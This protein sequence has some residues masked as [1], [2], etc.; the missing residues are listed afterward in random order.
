MDFAGATFMVLVVHQDVAAFRAAFGLGSQ[1][2][3]LPLPRR[4][5]VALVAQ[6]STAM[7]TVKF[8]VPSRSDC[9]ALDEGEAS[10]RRRHRIELFAASLFNT[11]T[12]RKYPA[13][14]GAGWCPGDELALCLFTDAVLDGK[15]SPHVRP[16][17]DV[18]E[19]AERPGV[20]ELYGSSM[21]LEL[22]QPVQEN[23][24]EVL[25]LLYA[26]FCSYSQHF[27]WIWGQ[28][29]SAI[30]AATGWRLSQRWEDTQGFATCADGCNAKRASTSTA[31]PT[32][33]NVV[34][35]PKRLVSQG[36][37]SG[38]GF[39]TYDGPATL[40][41]ILSWIAGRS[42]SALQSC[43]NCQVHGLEFYRYLRYFNHFQSYFKGTKMHEE[44]TGGNTFQKCETQ[45]RSPA[46]AVDSD[47][48]AWQSAA[49][50]DFGMTDAK[51]SCQLS[52]SVHVYPIP[53]CRVAQ[54]LDARDGIGWMFDANFLV[55]H[56]LSGPD[57]TG[58]E[59]RCLVQSAAMISLCLWPNTLLLLD[60]LVCATYHDSESLPTPNCSSLLKRILPIAC[61]VSILSHLDMRADIFHHASSLLLK[62][63]EYSEADLTHEVSRLLSEKA[64]L[65]EA[66]GVSAQLGGVMQ[67][68]YEEMMES[69]VFELKSFG[70]GMIEPITVGIILAVWL[71]SMC[72]IF[73]CGGMM[74]AY[75][76]VG[77][78]GQGSQDGTSG[79]PKRVKL[80]KKAAV[81]LYEMKFGSG[82]GSD[83]KSCMEEVS[84][85]GAS[86]LKDAGLKPAELSKDLEAKT[87][88]PKGQV[89]L[90]RAM[91][92]AFMA[93]HGATIAEHGLDQ[94][95][96]GSCGKVLCAG[97]LRYGLDKSGL[98]RCD[99]NC[100][101]SHLPDTFD[102]MAL[103]MGSTLVGLDELAGS[104]SKLIE[105][106]EEE[107]SNADPSTVESS[108]VWRLV[109]GIK[110]SNHNAYVSNPW[111]PEALQMLKM[112]D[113]RTFS[114]AFKPAGSL[115]YKGSCIPEKEYFKKHDVAIVGPNAKLPEGTVVKLDRV[116]TTGTQKGAYITRGELQT[117]LRLKDIRFGLVPVQVEPGVLDWL[118]ATNRSLPAIQDPTDPSKVFLAP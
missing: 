55:S 52:A 29:S 26:P 96:V 53:P 87:H 2:P 107:E 21:E 72:C 90:L 37:E 86:L 50:K 42:A 117:R 110:I 108:E 65:T 27:F 28:L 64:N 89:K 67:A 82:S 8:P 1:D 54:T 102:S 5:G 71:G 77:E 43:Q 112:P 95:G 31:N 45:R 15:V 60:A 22:L 101:A 115:Y 35:V 104:N 16:S 83:L 11:R 12:R 85:K 74:E 7:C 81:K 63:G 111:S 103:S 69:G 19:R 66:L 17:T 41:G 105:K 48:V 36:F 79:G 78:V 25:L 6:L 46:D 76:Q 3:A 80:M 32:V 40:A 10:S 49:R 13:P 4:E 94:L 68:T 97:D 56:G 14:G 9:S 34:A 91:A 20:K 62:Y 70:S 113:A 44:I 38:V 99:W 51:L 47:L 39:L 114:M 109:R 33:P 116:E 73:C 98:H 106:L 30:Q 18:Q 93:H 75:L 100:P 24:T 84:S 118:A 59:S 92:T 61:C 57:S 88:D 23:H 58:A